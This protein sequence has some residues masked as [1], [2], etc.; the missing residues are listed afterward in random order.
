MLRKDLEFSMRTDYEFGSVSGSFLLARENTFGIRQVMLLFP[1]RPC[2][3]GI[4]RFCA[5][6]HVCSGC[7][8]LSSAMLIGFYLFLT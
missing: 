5:V 6:C 3:N 4:V 2:M 8:C 7:V 1:F